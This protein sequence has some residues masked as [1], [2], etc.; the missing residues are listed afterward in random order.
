[1]LKATRADTY[2]ILQ[3]GGDEQGRRNG[4]MLQISWTLVAVHGMI[5]EKTSWLE[6]A[7][8]TKDSEAEL[9][10]REFYF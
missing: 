6:C 1:V 10:N 2:S 4:T 5:I 9:P 8:Q 3:F 7:G